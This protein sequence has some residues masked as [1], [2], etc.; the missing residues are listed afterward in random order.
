MRDHYDVHVLARK[1]RAFA[2][3][4]PRGRTCVESITHECMP[5][6][7]DQHSIAKRKEMLYNGIYIIFNG[8]YIF[9]SYY[10]MVIYI[11]FNIIIFKVYDTEQS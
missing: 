5:C 1:K 7:I 3:R 4:M 9:N 11:V 6:I 2:A 10:I 8:Y